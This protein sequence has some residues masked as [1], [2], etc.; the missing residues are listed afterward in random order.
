M[1]HAAL[2]R[3]ATSDADSVVYVLWAHADTVLTLFTSNLI[4]VAVARSLHYQFYSWYAHALPR[5]CWAAVPGSAA[6]S[7][8][9]RAVSGLFGVVVLG[10]VEYAWNV[11][12]ST[13]RSSLVLLGAHAV[14]IMGLWTSRR[15]RWDAVVRERIM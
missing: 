3:R 8:W 5:L 14:L 7:V 2:A 1:D 13:P 11:F 15:T 4:G 9:V 10:A 6:R 12:P